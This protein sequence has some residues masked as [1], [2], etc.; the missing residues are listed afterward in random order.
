M[1]ASAPNNLGGIKPMIIIKR[2]VLYIL[3]LIVY[4]VSFFLPRKQK[5]ILFISI[6]SKALNSDFK[7]IYEELAKKDYDIKFMSMQIQSN[8]RSSLKYVFSCMAQVIAIK[9]ASVVFIHDNNYVVSTFRFKKSKVI[10]IW[11][12]NGAIKKFGNQIKRAY[13]IRNYDVVLVPSTTWKAIYAQ[14]FNI[15]QTHIIECNL[16]RNDKLYDKKAVSKACKRMANTYPIILDKYVVLYAPTFRGNTIEGMHYSH[17]DLKALLDGLPDNYVILYKYHPLYKEKCNY[18]DER[19]IDCFDEE[20]FD[21]LCVSD[22]L[23][24]DYSS[25]IF[26]YSTMHKKM[27]LYAPD[28]SE[29]AR[30]VGFNIKYEEEMPGKIAHNSEELK[31]Y[32]INSEYDKQQVIRF[33][34]KYM[35]KKEKQWID[36]IMGIVEKQQ[37]IM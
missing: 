34:T 24:S 3:C 22:C 28:E 33:Q 11:H 30:N 2:T 13:P 23:I 19:I 26:D 21:L 32:L 8:W 4:I 9:R 16:P 12:A 37:E 10:Q 18:L 1:R 5:R 27:V 20:L 7:S 14:A 36:T 6:S 29:Y 35:P 31:Q 15:D 17:L 25:I